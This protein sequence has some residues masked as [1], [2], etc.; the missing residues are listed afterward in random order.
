M[1]IQMAAE[2]VVMTALTA[3][4]AIA[5]LKTKVSKCPWLMHIELPDVLMC[6][7]T[8]VLRYG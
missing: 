8:S 5:H 6:R 2:Q 3:L 7:T 4:P 1:V